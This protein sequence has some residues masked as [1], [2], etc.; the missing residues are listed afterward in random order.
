MG[1]TEANLERHAPI[2]AACG[3]LTPDMTSFQMWTLAH[4]VANT[5]PVRSRRMAREHNGE[6]LEAVE[7]LTDA[8]REEVRARVRANHPTWL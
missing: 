1:L 5:E 8:E 6:V 3:L 4:E 7:E 2:L